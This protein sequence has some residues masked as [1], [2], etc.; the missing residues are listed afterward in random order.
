MQRRAAAIFAV[1]FL[2]V[3][4]GAFAFMGLTEAPTVSLPGEAYAGGEEFSVGDRTYTV[5]E[6]IE[7]SSAQL[8]WRNESARFSATVENNS[9]VSPLDL[10]WEGQ[11]ARWSVTLDGDSTFTSENE[12]YRVAL[13]TTADPPSATLTNVDNAS[14]NE[15]VTVGDTL[16]YE[17]NETTITTIDDDGLTLV[18][19]ED[20]RAVVPNE[21]APDSVTFTQEFD[22]QDRL[23]RDRAIHN[24]TVT[25]DGIRSVVERDGNG[26]IPLEQYLPEADAA[27][28]SEGDQLT[29]RDNT[30]TIGNIT[31]E[32]VPLEWS[33]ERTET[34]DLSEGDNVTLNGQSYFAHFPSNSAV[35]I[36]PQDDYGTYRQQLS[37]IDYYDERIIGLWGVTLLSVITAILLLGLSYLP[38][39][40]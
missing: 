21:T 10:S 6:T 31:D 19:A 7:D 26:T 39:K 2:L 11:Q 33:G 28:F 35:Q 37:A 38:V 14:V 16:S 9:T 22:V 25:V 30:T 34:I 23:D 29:Y 20:Y 18:W 24:E 40:G 27:T 36:M 8:T 3:G 17:A 15:T 13:N 4:A 5:G 32:G 1:F 12:T